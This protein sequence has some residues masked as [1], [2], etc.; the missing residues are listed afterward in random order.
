MLS[1]R[2]V[3]LH[4]QGP[5]G[6]S[7]PAPVECAAPWPWDAAVKCSK[8]RRHREHTFDELDSP[9]HNFT[10]RWQPAP[11][12]RLLTESWNFPNIHD[13]NSQLER[14]TATHHLQSPIRTNE[15]N[16]SAVQQSLLVSSPNFHVRTI[17]ANG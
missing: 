17:K 16:D 4:T 7:G 8:L 10:D 13:S 5:S 1:A 6:M 14:V 2:L 12:H 9:H 11:S 15:A 3:A